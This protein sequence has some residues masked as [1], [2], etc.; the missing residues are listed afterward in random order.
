MKKIAAGAVALLGAAAILLWHH[1]EQTVRHDL[2]FFAMDTPL[3]L[4]AYGSRAPQALREAEGAVRALERELSVTEA[5][6]PIARLN[7]GK[8]IPVSESAV[9]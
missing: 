7:A 1:Q 3:T 8:V 2:S 6:S 9:E 5:H 4:S